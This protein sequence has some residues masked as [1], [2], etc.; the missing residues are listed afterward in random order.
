MYIFFSR[1]KL[2]G[3][4]IKTTTFCNIWCYIRFVKEMSSFLNLCIRFVWINVLIIVHGCRPYPYAWGFLKICTASPRSET[5]TN[6][7][8]KF[9]TWISM[10]REQKS[11]S[12]FIVLPVFEAFITCDLLRTSFSGC[13]QTSTCSE[14][15]QN[16]Y[17]NNTRMSTKRRPR[18]LIIGIYIIINQA[19]DAI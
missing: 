14:V 7:F 18:S 19:A 11:V 4:K 16:V 1:K 2:S 15:R 6:L 12:D 3:S 5:H 9:L 10:L 8:V 17:D 13:K